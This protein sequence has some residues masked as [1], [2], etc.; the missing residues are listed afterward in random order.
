MCSAVHD[1][2]TCTYGARETNTLNLYGVLLLDDDSNC[3]RLLTDEKSPC[4]Q[5]A[6]GGPLE[7]TLTAETSGAHEIDCARSEVG[8]SRSKPTGDHTPQLTLRYI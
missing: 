1:T 2:Q 8:V 7:T 4:D 6:H 5:I 3:S